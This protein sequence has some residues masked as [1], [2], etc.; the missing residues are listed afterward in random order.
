MKKLPFLLLVLIYPLNSCKK[1]SIEADALA[2]IKA[3]DFSEKTDFFLK[4]GD[5]LDM[6]LSML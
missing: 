2:G 5:I 1:I 3:D 6:Q 4:R